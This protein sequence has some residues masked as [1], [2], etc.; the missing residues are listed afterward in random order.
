LLEESGLATCFVGF[1]LSALATVVPSLFAILVLWWLDRYEKEPLWLLS[2]VFVWGA[3]PAVLLS[4]IAQLTATPVLEVA[5]GDSILFPL[6]NMGLVA[7]LTEETF[8]ALMLLA[9]FV[10]YR[11]EFNG[12]MDGILYGALIGF[13]FSIVEDIFYLMGSL[14]E[15][16]WSEWG[17]TAALRIG[18]YNLNHSLFTASTGVGFG[19][20]SGASRRWQRWLYPFL[21][22][23]AGV[24]LHAVH[25]GG[26]VLA[27]STSGLSW[28]VLTAVDWI[29][30]ALMAALI[31]VSI[32]REKQWFVELVPEMQRGIITRD[33]YQLASA[34]RVRVRRG[35]RVLLAHGPLVWLKW[36]RFVQ[37][38]VDLA[39]RKHRRRV[40]HKDVIAP[41]RSTT[42]DEPIVRLRQR[43]ALLRP[44]LAALGLRD[45]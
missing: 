40:T 30:V 16:G 3:V 32:R 12:V 19:L 45:E 20:A 22:W 6:A 33:E 14:Y 35:W 39:Y 18:L 5:F 23:L 44:E 38:I 15:G 42:G 8:K 25:N 4:L 1:V 37:L 28:L 2:I 27:E 21:G 17:T 11:A 7:P 13:G 31:W 26:I 36:S 29:G 34:Y 43:I 24:T 9:L 41:G 10:L